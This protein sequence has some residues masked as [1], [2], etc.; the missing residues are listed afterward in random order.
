MR[1]WF[2]ERQEQKTIKKPGY[3]YE[4]CFRITPLHYRLIASMT[5]CDAFKQHV[6]NALIQ[7]TNVEQNV[8]DQLINGK[9]YIWW[10]EKYI[11]F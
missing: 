2:I 6:R 9:K 7:H 4:Y 11:V 10:T 8:I 1:G 3:V 5:E